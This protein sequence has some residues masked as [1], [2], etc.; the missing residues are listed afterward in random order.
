[1]AYAGPLADSDAPANGP[2]NVRQIRANLASAGWLYCDGASL[3]CGDYRELFGVIGLAHG[4]SD[5]RFNLPD[6]RGRFVR[7]VN[8]DALIDPTAEPPQP[9][10]P[11]KSAR[12][13]SQSGGNTG[14]RVGSVQRDAFQGHEHKYVAVMEMGTAEPGPEPAYA[15]NPVAQVTTDDVPDTQDDGKPRTAQE[16]RPINIYLNYIIRFR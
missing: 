5:G 1:M 4:G 2:I 15:P 11:G 12:T 3:P 13:A 10:D 14:N 8:S 7:G 6:L 9:R 16:T